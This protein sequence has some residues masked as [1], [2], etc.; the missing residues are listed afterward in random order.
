MTTEAVDPLIGTTIG[1]YEIK[2]LLG[3]GAMGQV[4][5][6]EHPHIGRKV[7]VKVLMASFSSNPEMADRFMSEA[8]AVNRFNHP[9]IIQVFDFGKLPDGRLYLIMEF[10]EGQELS[11]Y[12]EERGTL[13]IDETAALMGQIASAL[14]AAHSAG[15]VHRDLKPDNI[16]IVHTPTGSTVKVLD[17]GVAKLLDPENMGAKHKTATGLIM[18]TPSYMSPE[19]ARGIGHQIGPSTDIYALG[20]IVYQMLS[21]H[22]PIDAESVTQVLLKHITDPPVPIFEY[23]PAFPPPLWNVIAMA[24]EKNIENRPPSAGAFHQ[25]FVNA[26]QGIPS[27]ITAVGMVS[28][29]PARSTLP[30]LSSSAVKTSMTG[31]QIIEPVRHSSAIWGIIAGIVVVVLG[32]VWWFFLRNKSEAETSTPTTIADMQVVDDMQPKPTTLPSD[33]LPADDMQ[34]PD[35]P[36]EKNDM[37]ATDMPPTPMVQLRIKSAQSGLVFTLRIGSEPEFEARTPFE[38]QVPVGQR[39]WISPKDPRYPQKVLT[40]TK[41]ETLELQAD[42]SPTMRVISPMPPSERSMTPSNMSKIGEDTIKIMF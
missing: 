13:S 27:H 32:G 15:I 34:T 38:I 9:N 35:M 36:P 5:L 26:A 24:L 1:N 37:L 33:M 20:V 10:L 18:G 19:Q 16:F 22:L 2:S 40:P 30:G 39:V 25:M 8:K 14:D 3:A 23:L 42:V 6:G 4:F 28:P 21:G 7:A 12:M 41:D 11:A 29:V 17:F 31:E